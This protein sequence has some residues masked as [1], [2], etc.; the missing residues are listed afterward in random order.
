MRE[1]INNKVYD[2][3]K[4]RVKDVVETHDRNSRDYGT[5]VVISNHESIERT[6]IIEFSDGMICVVITD[7]RFND[8]EG[9][10]TIHYRRIRTLHYKEGWIIGNGTPYAIG[11]DDVIQYL[12]ECFNDT[13]NK[14]VGDHI[15]ELIAK[16]S[17]NSL[18]IVE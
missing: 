18:E 6:E 9:E 2:L 1:I 5:T 3:R 13:R 12:K 7:Y 8:E 15:L 14:K 16:Y 4:G 10:P 11:K 17:G